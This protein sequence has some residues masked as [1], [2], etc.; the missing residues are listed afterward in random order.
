[1]KV[2][3]ITLMFTVAVLFLT[4]CNT[5]QPTQVA[6]TATRADNP[7]VA[8]V[9]TDD[10]D[11]YVNDDFDLRRVGDVLQRSNSP[12]EFE[13]YLNANNGINNLDLNG[14]GYADYI[15]V[16]EFGDLNSNERGLSLYTNYGT[17]RR[18]DLGTVYFYRD[19]P[20]Y[21][22][23]RV[24]MTGN[25]NIYGDNNFYE[26]NWLEKSIGIISQLFSP[27]REQ[28]RS[29]YYYNN[30]PTGYTAYN[31]VEQPIYRTR[32]EQMFPQP[33]F[34]YTATAPD[35]YSKIKIKSPNNG[36]HLGQI[37]G[38]VIKP[39][40]EQE[41]FYKTNPRRPDRP[42]SDDKRLNDKNKPGKPDDK[43]VNDG[44]KGN[45]DKGKG[46]KPEKVDKPDNGKPDKGGKGKGK[47]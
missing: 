15:S 40:K 41:D 27:K 6:N 44:P 11:G 1:M 46:G 34:V 10:Q 30:Y 37:Y 18:Q 47:N 14:D 31:V 45:D 9:P 35:Y 20:Q 42:Q 8:T 36:L 13:T 21:P 29:P 3:K 16:D 43:K 22:G 32:I 2:S 25:D 19:Q 28:Y 5:G 39:T 38:K 23:A 7:T 12:Q 17:D 26:T 24:V 33:I 4:A